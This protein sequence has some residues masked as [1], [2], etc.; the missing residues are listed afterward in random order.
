MIDRMML[1]ETFL[2]YYCDNFL[3][4]INMYNLFLFYRL[5]LIILNHLLDQR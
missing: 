1:L 2:F 5:N 3:V 4:I